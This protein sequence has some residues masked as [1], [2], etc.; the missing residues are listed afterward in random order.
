MDR[1][2]LDR[3]EGVILYI[4]I[5]HLCQ[6]HHLLVLPCLEVGRSKVAGHMHP[7]PSTVLAVR[8]IIPCVLSV[9][10]LIRVSVG[11]RR[12]VV[13]SVVTWVTE[14]EIAYK[15]DKGIVTIASDPDS[16]C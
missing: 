16:D 7:S 3:R 10:G 15:M 14:L 1:V 8:Q 5:I 13:S 11:V 2:R 12:V 6:H 4:R 9:A